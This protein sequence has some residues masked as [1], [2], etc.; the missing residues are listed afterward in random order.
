MISLLHP[1]EKCSTSTFGPVPNS[2]AAVVR[3]FAVLGRFIRLPTPNNEGDGFRKL[4]RAVSRLVRVIL[5][6][7]RAGFATTLSSTRMIFADENL[8]ERWGDC[9]SSQH[10]CNCLCELLGVTKSETILDPPNWNTRRE[11]KLLNLRFIDGE[12]LWRR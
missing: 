1:E 3:P 11:S 6:M 5:K 2:R 8:V 7:S 9:L 4:I 10:G 12:N